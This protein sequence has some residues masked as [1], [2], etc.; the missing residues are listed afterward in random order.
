MVLLF[1][2]ARIL[3]VRSTEQSF[4]RS[5]SVGA[6]HVPLAHSTPVF[7]YRGII[8]PLLCSYRGGSQGLSSTYEQAHVDLDLLTLASLYNFHMKKIFYLYVRLTKRSKLSNSRA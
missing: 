1:H 2:D 4:L 5:A 3:K 7:A 6:K 8:I